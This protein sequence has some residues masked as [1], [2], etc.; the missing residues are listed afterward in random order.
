ML[1]DEYIKYAYDKQRYGIVEEKPAKNYRFGIRLSPFFRKWIT[2][3]ECDIFSTCWKY[4]HFYVRCLDGWDAHHCGECP[5]T[6]DNRYSYSS[7]TFSVIRMK[8]PK[9]IYN[10]EKSI[11]RQGCQSEYGN[12]NTD[13]FEKF[14]CST[15]K[16]SPQPWRINENSCCKRN[17][18]VRE[19]QLSWTSVDISV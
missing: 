10:G 17:L 5:N 18:K 19:T 4:L 9:W 8:F 15:N 1:S 16:I 2:Y 7:R 13:I 11:T 14:R 3:F 6:C 12:P